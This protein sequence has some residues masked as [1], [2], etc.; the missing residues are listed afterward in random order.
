MTSN[1][2]MEKSE[3]TDAVFFVYGMESCLLLGL[4][5]MLDNGSWRAVSDTT[6]NFPS[7]DYATPNEAAE[8]LYTYRNA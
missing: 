8:A 6:A 2:V 4:V 5:E 1:V 3:A 7:G